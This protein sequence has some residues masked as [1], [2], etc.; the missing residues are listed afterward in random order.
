MKQ[1][2]EENFD[3]ARLGRWMMDQTYKISDDEVANKLS[4]LGEELTELNIPFGRK[5]E[6]LS[7]VDRKIIINCK[8]IFEQS[9]TGE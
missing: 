1:V 9:I 8:N 5:W 4:F 3:A 2:F 6:T 7:A